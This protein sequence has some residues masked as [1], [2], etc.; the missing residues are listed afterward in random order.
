MGEFH[1]DKA[2]ADKGDTLRTVGQ[3]QEIGAG[4]QKLFAFDPER[5]WPRPGGDVE[6]PR[7]IRRAINLDRVG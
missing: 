5:R 6:M 3:L 1:R 2:A 7:A 4:D